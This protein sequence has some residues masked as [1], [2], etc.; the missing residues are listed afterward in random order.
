[1]KN[2]DPLVMMKLQE[3]CR[4]LNTIWMSNYRKPN[5]ILFLVS[6]VSSELENYN[7]Y[8][9]LISS[10]VLAITRS[11]HSRGGSS[12]LTRW[13]FHSNAPSSMTWVKKATKEVGHVYHKD[14]S[15]NL[16]ACVYGLMEK[17]H[18]DWD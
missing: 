2:N 10:K 6:R 5:P 12:S 17:S 8:P 18:Q 15:P 4:S 13:N 7:N 3:V 11:R 1:M 9:L 16:R 14:T